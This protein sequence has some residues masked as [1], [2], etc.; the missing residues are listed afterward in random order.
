[1]RMPLFFHFLFLVSALAVPVD[2]SASP[3][4]TAT[5]VAPLSTACAD[6]VNSCGALEDLTFPRFKLMTNAEFVFTAQQAFD[7]L[8]S[9]PFN[10]GVATQFL[11]YYNDTLQFQ[12]TS[13]Y[14][15]N[16]PTSYQQPA[17]DLLHGLSQIQQDV[18]DGVFENQ[19]AFEAT[20]QNLVQQAHDTH[21]VLDFGILNAFSFGSPYGIVSVSPDGAENPKVY[22]YGTLDRSNSALVG[23]W[24]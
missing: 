12:S 1:M 13:A 9:V 10:P 14:L 16:P 19:Y 8:S 15:K 18:N 7:C 2:S 3:T 20:L 6:I 11:T 4:S 24:I 17:V 5:S 21:L 22:S 23:Q